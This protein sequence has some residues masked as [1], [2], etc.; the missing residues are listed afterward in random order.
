M[1]KCASTRLQQ[2]QEKGGR[3]SGLL[4]REGFSGGRG[5]SPARA[6]SLPEAWPVSPLCPPAAG[7]VRAGVAPSPFLSAAS[8][9]PR[10]PSECAAGKKRPEQLRRRIE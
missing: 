3:E 10:P 8:T 4:L 2:H 5:V 1:P 6:A 7:G 9:H